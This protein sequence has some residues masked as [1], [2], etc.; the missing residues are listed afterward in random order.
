[1]KRRNILNEFALPVTV[2]AAFMVFMTLV[3]FIAAYVWRLTFPLAWIPLWLW[4]SSLYTYVLTRWAFERGR[5][6]RS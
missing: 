4:L 1:M 6:W 2:A 3:C 5:S